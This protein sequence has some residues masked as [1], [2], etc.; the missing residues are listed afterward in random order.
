MDCK[1]LGKFSSEHLSMILQS[2]CNAIGAGGLKGVAPGKG[3]A[4]GKQASFVPSPSLD[5]L[6]A[7]SYEDLPALDSEQLTLNQRRP[8]LLPK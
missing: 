7:E 6:R 3:L 5:N 2:R 4:R 1:L 8:P